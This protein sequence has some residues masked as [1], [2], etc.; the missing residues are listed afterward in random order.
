MKNRIEIRVKYCPNCGYFR[1]SYSKENPQPPIP[2]HTVQLG[3]YVSPNICPECY[4]EDSS[5]VPLKLDV[6]F[7]RNIQKYTPEQ[8]KKIEGKRE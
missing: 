3:T 6:H 7:I 1:R 4:Q 5:Q 8:I 2:A